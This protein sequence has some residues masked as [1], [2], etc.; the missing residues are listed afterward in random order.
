MALKEFLF[1]QEDQED[2]LKQILLCKGLSSLLINL[3]AG[4]FGD[5][6]H[7]LLWAGGKFTMRSLEDEKT[8][9]L[10]ITKKEIR[11]FYDISE[12]TDENLYYVPMRKNQACVDSIVVN[13]G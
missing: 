4:F 12:C 1:H 6:A 3:Q 13:M 10:V 7:R 5:Y 8:F 2:L 9:D 11:K